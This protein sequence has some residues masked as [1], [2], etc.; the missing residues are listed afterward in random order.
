M[1]Q[2]N[3][4]YKLKEILI[5][6]RHRKGLS[7]QEVADAVGVSLR[8]YQR[9]EQGEVFP[10]A[11]YLQN[12]RGFLGFDIDEVTTATISQQT[13]Q[14]Q[15]TYEQSRHRTHEFHSLNE[16]DSPTS[17][18]QKETVA[19]SETTHGEAETTYNKPR[20]PPPS[21]HRNNAGFVHSKAWLLVVL[22]VVGS[23]FL[24]YG[25]Y[26]FHSTS[27][28]PGGAW[29][30][31]PDKTVQSNVHFAAYAYPTHEGEPEI[32]HV[33]FTLYW[34][35][36]DPRSWVIGCVA[37]KPIKKDIFACD[38]NLT[39]LGVPSGQ[40]MVSFDVYDQQ[41]HHNNS[42]NGI[43]TLLYLPETSLKE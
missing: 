33:N 15:Q 24:A 14:E 11:H 20:I 8:N 36:D 12:V 25:L 43:H 7:Q 37:H 10:Q 16:H 31:P 39:V 6:E 34:Q 23:G 9:W 1:P 42:P 19:F 28:K 2:L 4:K 13:I 40:I 41:G 35:G 27:I 18:L 29:I 21:G 32:D 17:S 5:R 26:L 30:S 22:A 38:V 3:K